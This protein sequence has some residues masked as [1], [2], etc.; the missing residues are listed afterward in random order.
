MNGS[1]YLIKNSINSKVYVGQTVQETEKRFEQH[2][3]LL[4]SNKNQAIHKAIKSMGK[5]KFSFEI[6]KTEITSY[7][8][9]NKLE[10]FFINK[11]NS[12]VPNGYNLCPGGQKW[13]RVHEFSDELEAKIASEYK[14]GK[15][16]R[17]L[18]EIYNCSKFCILSI[19]KRQRCQT[20]SKAVSLPNRTSKLTE[21]LMKDLYLNKRMKIKDIAELLNVNVRTV[22]RAKNRYNLKRI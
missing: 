10:E 2:L 4:K 17:N 1:I 21:E 20:R 14:S 5:E 15:T 22:N 7:E 3:K 12:I 11:F 6:I 16:S 9:L 13:R 8:E 19:L 18:A